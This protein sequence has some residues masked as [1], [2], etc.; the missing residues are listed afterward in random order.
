MADVRIYLKP[1]SL[2]SHSN[3]LTFHWPSDFEYGPFFAE[4][5]VIPYD[6]TQVYTVQS[7]G[8][9]A[10]LSTLFDDVIPSLD[11]EVPDIPIE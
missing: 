11:A 3:Y 5:Q 7:P 9:S 4:H 2:H 6:A 1:S 10:S 8:L